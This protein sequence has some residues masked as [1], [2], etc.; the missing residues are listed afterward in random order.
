MN[1]KNGPAQAEHLKVIWLNLRTL[2]AD[3]NYLALVP[4][5]LRISPKTEEL[6]RPTHRNSDHNRSTGGLSAPLRES[7]DAGQLRGFSNSHTCTACPQPH[8]SDEVGGVQ[9]DPE[10]Q[11]PWSTSAN[12]SSTDDNN[13][14]PD[15]G[16]MLEDFVIDVFLTQQRARLENT[17]V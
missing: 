16:F 12:R 13:D 1:R 15:Q 10:Q 14:K 3:P 2:D 17:L 11:S 5:S 4:D 7:K 8:N 6:G 9:T